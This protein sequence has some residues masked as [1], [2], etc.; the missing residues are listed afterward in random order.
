MILVQVCASPSKILFSDDALTQDFTKANDVIY[1]EGTAT[2][3]I[4]NIT[5]INTAGWF[6]VLFYPMAT[7]NTEIACLN[8]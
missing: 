7:T 3:W 5:K 8:I 1:G 4:S 6:Y 2:F